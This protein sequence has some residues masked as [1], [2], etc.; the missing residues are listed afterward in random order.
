MG[1]NY[2]KGKKSVDKYKKVKEINLINIQEIFQILLQAK[3]K[4]EK[5]H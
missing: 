3:I 4:F 5:I 2:I 1:D